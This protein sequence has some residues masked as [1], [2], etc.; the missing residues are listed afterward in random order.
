M[1]EK[2]ND[3]AF[4]R[5]LATEAGNLKKFVAI[6]DG[7]EVEQSDDFSTLALNTGNR[8]SLLPKTAKVDIYS[9]EEKVATP[10]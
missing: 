8:A 10:H 4:K 1:A 9:T 3:R 2:I 6:I 7:A 5:L